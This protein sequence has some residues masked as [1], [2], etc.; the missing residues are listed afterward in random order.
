MWSESS[1]LPRGGVAARA[2][3]R[4]GSGRAFA[5]GA[6]ALAETLVGRFDLDASGASID[7]G[8]TVL[9]ERTR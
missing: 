8:Q 4:V 3:P 2:A 5:S 7:A 9:R 6:T 1:V